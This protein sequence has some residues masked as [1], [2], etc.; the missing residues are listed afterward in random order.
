MIETLSI[1]YSQI[2]VII[3]VF[4]HLDVHLNLILTSL[5]PVLMYGLLFAII[6]CET[7]LIVTPFLPG[8]SLLFALG[9][10]SATEGSPL[11][12]G[13]LFISL[14]MAAILGDYTNYSI[15]FIFGKKILQK[16]RFWINEDHILKTKNFFCYSWRKNDFLGTLSS[17]L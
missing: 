7:G 17:H 1:L 11:C 8:D 16:K 14:L 15:G 5:G 4:L 3:D 9:A 2:L 13:I 12:L 10:L 6:F